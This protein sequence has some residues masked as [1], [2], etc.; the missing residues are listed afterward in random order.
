M[1]I[2]IVSKIFIYI[3]YVLGKEDPSN[4]ML[5]WILDFI[6]KIHIV[7]LSYQLSSYIRCLMRTLFCI[8]GGKQSARE[9]LKL[10]IFR[11][12]HHCSL[13]MSQTATSLTCSRSILTKD[14]LV[15]GWILEHHFLHFPAND[16]ISS[17]LASHS[18]QLSFFR[19]VPLVLQRWAVWE[20]PNLTMKSAY[21]CRDVWG[22]LVPE[23]THVHTF[24]LHGRRGAVDVN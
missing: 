3:E 24:K 18:A 5:Y 4:G 1:I 19:H 6:S 21:M 16:S 14:T 7:V 12:A 20:F 9:S 11:E 15:G 23:N 17:S 2:C 10:N 13:M 22:V 8:Q